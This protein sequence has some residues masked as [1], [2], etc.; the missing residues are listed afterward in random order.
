MIKGGTGRRRVPSIWVTVRVKQG[1]SGRGGEPGASS[2]YAGARTTAFAR[3][4]LDSAKGGFGGLRALMRR[5]S[6]PR[7]DA[8]VPHPFRTPFVF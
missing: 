3:K 6:A 8:D 1:R 5:Y 2:A 7:R 4:V